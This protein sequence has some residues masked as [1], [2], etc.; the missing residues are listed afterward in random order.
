MRLHR[1][2]LVLMLPLAACLDV[3]SDVTVGEDEVISADTTMILGRQLFDMMQMMGPQGAALCP[4][5]AER[6]ETPETV[7]CKS[8]ETMTIDEA[9]EQANTAKKDDPFLSEMEFAKLDDERLKI[10]LPLDF[11][12]IEGKPS[13]LTDDNPMFSMITGGLE[14]SEIVMR[15]RALE[16]ESSNGT[17]SE[18]RTMVELVIPTVEILQ[19]SQTLPKT[20]DVVLKYRDCG[21]FGC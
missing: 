12:N 21:F 20:F 5:D 16:I 10:S 2:A 9:I 19:P 18:D 13:E 17:I 4:A 8:R 1:I 3:E 6:V 11:E 15:L 14:G 7:S